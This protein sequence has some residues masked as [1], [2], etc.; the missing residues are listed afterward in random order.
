MENRM[1][2]TLAYFENKANSNNPWM[3]RK[4]SHTSPRAKKKEEKRQNNKKAPSVELPQQAQG[5]SCLRGTGEARVLPGAVLWIPRMQCG[6][7]CHLR[8]PLYGFQRAIL[9]KCGIR[10]LEQVLLQRVFVNNN[11]VSPDFVLGRRSLRVWV[12]TN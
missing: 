6:V 3:L 2:T 5:R 9:G 10:V 7:H 1:E 4:Y 11:M 8:S 12:R